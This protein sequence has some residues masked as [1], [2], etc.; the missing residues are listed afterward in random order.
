MHLSTLT[1]LPEVIGESIE[2]EVHSD[3]HKE[4]DGKRAPEN[5]HG[6][7]KLIH[8]F[9]GAVTIDGEAYRV[10]T[11]VVESRISKQQNFPL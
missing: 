5:G 6:E 1:V 8:R 10:R 7:D 3:Y 4:E 9:Y 11:T 2:A